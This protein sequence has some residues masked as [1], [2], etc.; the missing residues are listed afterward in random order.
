MILIYAFLLGLT[1]KYL[2]INNKKKYSVIILSL[3]LVISFFFISVDIITEKGF[4][5][6]F[7]YH[8]NQDILSGSYTPYLNKESNQS[9]GQSNLPNLV[10]TSLLCLLRCSNVRC[11]FR[12]EKCASTYLLEFCGCIPLA[13]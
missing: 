11:F 13:V 9:T 8:L 6:A 5:R 7:W 3:L 4:S 10:C 1:S 12:Y 2:L